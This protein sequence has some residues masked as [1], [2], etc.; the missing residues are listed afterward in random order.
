MKEFSELNLSSAIRSNLAKHGFVTPT[1]VQAQAIPPALEG[2]DV[3]ATAQT[4]TGKTLGFALPVMQR[5]VEQQGKPGT[6]N[7]RAVV[8]SPTR[9]LAI[10][11]NETFMKIGG[12]TGVRTAVV[13]GGMDESRQLRAIRAGA[14]VVIA[15]PGRLVDFLQRRLIDL[16]G[17]TV[18]VLDE[19]DRMLDMGFMPSLKQ[20]LAAMPESRQTMLFSAT[21]EKSVSHLVESSVRNPVRIAIGAITRPAEH[22][23]LHV[24]EI[25]QGHKMDLLQQLLRNQDGSF[26]VFS[27]TKHGADRLA[28]NLE[29]TGVNAT[30]IHGD[31]TQGQRNAALS[32]FKEGKFRVLVATDVAARGI[33]VDGIAHVVNFDLPQ[34]PEDFIHRAGRT[35]RA[36]RRGI[37]STFSTRAERSEIRRIERALNVKMQQ[38]PFTANPA[39][40][41]SQASFLEDRDEPVMMVEDEAPAITAPVAQVVV[42]KSFAP[43]SGSGGYAGGGAGKFS[44]SGP[45]GPK[46]A[47]GGGKSSSFGSGKPSFGGSSKSSG[48]GAAGKPWAG[49]NGKPAGDSGKSWGSDN[50]PSFGAGSKSAGPSA[51]GGKAPFGAGKPSKHKK[52]G[53]HSPWRKDW[54]SSGST[55][56]REATV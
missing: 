41:A 15:T 25:E 56:R 46:A 10:Q 54:R 26:L 55:S 29:R 23:D 21:I 34:V 12:N 38:L 37:A 27:R 22:V 7:I 53:G 3:V 47:F 4:G 42:R 36:G 35:G 11:I 14:Q 5:L 19:A 48:N 17:V 44:K 1:P 40:A 30:R 6:G 32:G 33:H 31:R 43:K 52:A 51:G 13:V 18:A 9:E 20:I 16:R 24:Y 2:K 39:H 28:R 50:K 8:L 45:R 49:S